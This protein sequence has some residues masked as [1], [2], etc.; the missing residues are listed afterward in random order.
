MEA[1]ARRVGSTR[2]VRLHLDDQTDARSLLGAYVATHVAGQFLWQA[3]PLAQVLTLKKVYHGHCSL[4]VGLGK[5]VGGV[6]RPEGL[7]LPSLRHILISFP[8]AFHLFHYITFSSTPL[9]ITSRCHILPCMA[10]HSH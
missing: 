2:L 8:W 10:S 5:S 6:W 1:L 7:L 9:H 3:G 4:S